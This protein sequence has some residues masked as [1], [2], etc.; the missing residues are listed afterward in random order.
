MKRT[1]LTFG[2][3]N[4]ANLAVSDTEQ[5]CNQI[6]IDEMSKFDLRTVY[7]PDTIND[8]TLNLEVIVYTSDDGLDVEESSSTWHPMPLDSDVDGNANFEPDIVTYRRPASST[9]SAKRNATVGFETSGRKIRFG[10][11][12]QTTSGAA[13][14]DTGDITRAYLS[15]RS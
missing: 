9:L 8:T 7:D 10:F 4:V 6:D 12:E 15:S 11:T 13:A 1:Q 14:S 5:F 2:T 3:N